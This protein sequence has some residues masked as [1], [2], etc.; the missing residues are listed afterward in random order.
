MKIKII[1]MTILM[2]FIVA[3]CSVEE[4]QEQDPNL[5]PGDISGLPMDDQSTD[6]DD[7]PEIVATI[8]GEPITSEEISSLS[9]ERS[10]MGMQYS[11]DQLVEEM[12][13]LRLLYDLGHELDYGFTNEDAEQLLIEEGQ[14][15]DDLK[16]RAEEAGITYENI[17]V[18]VIAELNLNAL[19]MEIQE[20]VDIP[21]EEIQL[22]YN[23]D[24]EIQEYFSYEEFKEYVHMQY[25]N[26]MLYYLLEERYEQAEIEY[27]Y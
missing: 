15:I 20:E 13:T 11:V 1:L 4:P 5:I 22:M 3:G 7:L 24:V 17:L 2:V 14:D 9:F 10:M 8:N 16:V 23:E 12:I 21:E 18:D 6:F 27:F 25:S 26:E 19:F